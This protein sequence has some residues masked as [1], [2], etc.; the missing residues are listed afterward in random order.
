[1]NGAYRQT[2]L[3]ERRDRRGSQIGRIDPGSGGGLG[4][5]DQ[6]RRR[7]QLDKNTHR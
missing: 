6:G 1:M 5:S 3:G 2:R 7:K 4:G